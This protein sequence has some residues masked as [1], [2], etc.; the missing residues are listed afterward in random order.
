MRQT[1][2]ALFLLAATA[3][4]GQFHV[5][6]TCNPGNNGIVNPKWLNNYV[7]AYT[8]DNWKHWELIRDQLTWQG[9]RD[10]G[11]DFYT[12]SYEAPSFQ[13]IEEAA[14]YAEQFTSAIF[15]G[16][17]E[18]TAYAKHLRLSEKWRLENIRHPIRSS[19]K[20]PPNGQCAE[21]MIH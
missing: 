15:I 4:Q 12:S 21:K 11:T 8:L 13:T 14:D 10:D 5:K 20:E 17:Y 7:V 3:G 18:A 16:R 1:F 2:I 19:T 9:F 6:V